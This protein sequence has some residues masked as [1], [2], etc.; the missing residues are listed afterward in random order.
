VGAENSALRR[1]FGPKGNDVVAEGW[2]KLCNEDM[3]S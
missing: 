2:R 1:M 3:I